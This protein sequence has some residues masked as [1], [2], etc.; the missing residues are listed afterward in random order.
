MTVTD[1]GAAFSSTLPPLAI[2]PR[3]AAEAARLALTRPHPLNLAETVVGHL[4]RRAAHT[5]DALAVVHKE[6]RLT[7]AD[8]LTHVYALRKELTERG[9]K[10]GDVIACS[11][12]RSATTLALFLALE[13]LGAVYLPVD[14]TWP[15]SRTATVLQR[16]GAA[17]LAAY[18]P[19]NASAESLR[20]AALL[21]D[22]PIL[23]VELSAPSAEGRLHHEARA[24]TWPEKCADA[25]EARYVFYTSGTT[26]VPKGALNEHQGMVN[27]LWAKVLD[28]GLTPSDVIAF[29]APLVFDISIWQML[30]PA[31]AGSVMVVVD[32]ADVHFP[33]RLVTELAVRQVTVLEA[34]P[35][36]L[37]MLT[38]EVARGR[39]DLSALRWVISTGEEL[40]PSTAAD[41]IDA[42]PGVE[43]SNAW[44]F[45]ETSDD[46]T[47]HVVRGADLSGR[48]LPVGSPVV[49]ACL[50]VL[51]EAEDGAWRA[52][53][54]GEIGEIFVG[55]VA[56]CRGYL[57]D[58]AAT[59]GAFHRD[60]IDPSSPT[61]RLHRSGD[62]GV[63][64]DGLLYYLGRLDR[65]VKVKGVRMELGE[66]EAV[67]ACHHSVAQCAVVVVDE[68][69]ER[70][71]VACYV[72]SGAST[73]GAVLATELQDHVR[74]I[75]PEAMVP[76]RWV[77]FL[78]L[79]LNGN[80]KVDHKKLQRMLSG[81]S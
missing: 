10:P 63:I 39:V 80:G 50:Y 42:L 46:L 77:S 11:G 81:R 40:L 16:S 41:L 32:D 7:C 2:P 21:A 54:P 68:G 53:A 38:E 61:G 65:Q 27:H 4:A 25:S 9:C 29:S 14:P 28:H 66:I 62:A 58:P 45:T 47:H 57:Q 59:K 17:L 30:V 52:A 5:P 23:S 6:S 20:A 13:S 43:V 1:Q 22:V 73:E 60:V 70:E 8:L 48:R 64:R 18:L 72:S 78:S 71:L 35:T 37:R 74:L 26:G 56:V 31:L 3:Q 69:T 51:V 33:R 79:P 12:L 44:G 55:G 24:F 67:L 76:L 36:L 75:L 34:V 19:S 49:N 15:Q